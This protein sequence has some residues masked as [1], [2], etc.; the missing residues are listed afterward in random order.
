MRT[1]GERCL[2]A[3][4][5]NCSCIC[6]GKNHGSLCRETSEVD[7]KQEDEKKEES[8]SD[9]EEKDKRSNEK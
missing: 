2:Y 4:Y 6:G 7:I 1:C 3:L 9:S 5:N 8:T